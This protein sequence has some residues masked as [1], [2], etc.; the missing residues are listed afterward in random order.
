MPQSPD[1]LLK[2]SERQTNSCDL[3]ETDGC[4]SVIP[5]VLCLQFYVAP[6]T[7]YY[8]EAPFAGSTWSGTIAGVSFQAYWER[9]YQT[10]ECEFVVAVNGIVVY[11][12]SCYEGASCRHPDGSTTV[13]IGEDEGTLTWSV[14]E[15]RPLEYIQDPDSGCRTYFCD[16]CECSCECLC[17]TITE[18]DTTTHLGEICD[19]AYDCDAPLWVGT[20]GGYDLS[21]SMGRDEYGRCIITP[22]VD[23][24]EQDAVL[25]PGCADAVTS[26]TL[27]D[28]TTIAL[29]C[30]RCS[31]EEADTCP[32]C[33][34]WPQGASGSIAWTT[35]AVA[36]D[37]EDGSEESVTGDFSC[38]DIED[39]IGTVVRERGTDLNVRLFCDAETQQW[40]AQYRSAISGG[41]FEPPIST[42]W[43]DATEV[44]FV[45]P[46]CADAVDGQA[47]G[48]VSFI[49]KMACETSGGVVEYDVLVVG[50][51]TIGCP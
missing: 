42:T 10:D 15:S 25:F 34:G 18:T 39:P 51:V 45:C 13:T 41:T 17:V 49:A 38:E 1:R 43:A 9:D 33:P 37:C 21:M 48:S 11:R 23:G 35:S 4:C 16:D 7:Y 29:T 22:T 40:K 44:E 8:G 50:L 28:G 2:C 3:T 12:K 32:C 26:V 24:I 30:K 36:N 47:T 19:T 14:F 6:S 27:L 46:D 5:C 31:C 20:V